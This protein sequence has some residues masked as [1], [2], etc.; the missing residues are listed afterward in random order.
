MITAQWLG[1]PQIE[2]FVVEAV[3]KSQFELPKWLGNFVW[4]EE[5]P[6][7]LEWLPPEDGSLSA[8][9]LQEISAL[10][11]EIERDPFGWPKV[12]K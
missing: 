4:H 5:I 9:E 12:R 6:G 11:R 1:K 3:A 7:I 8:D 10:M 2:G